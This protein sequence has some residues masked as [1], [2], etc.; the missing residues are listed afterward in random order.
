M[1]G[2]DSLK[3]SPFLCLTVD[4]TE[5]REPASGSNSGMH[6][7]L[8][9]ALHHEKQSHATSIF[10]SRIMLQASIDFDDGPQRTSSHTSL[11]QILESYVGVI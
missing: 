5:Y 10:G 7:L 4:S 1:T 11:E 9:H 6:K 8:M 3:Q 2:S